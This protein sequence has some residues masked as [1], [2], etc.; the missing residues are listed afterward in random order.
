MY[1]TVY[2]EEMVIVVIAVTNTSLSAVMSLAVVSLRRTDWM[3]R[4]IQLLV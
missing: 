3:R 4:L 2:Y 1:V